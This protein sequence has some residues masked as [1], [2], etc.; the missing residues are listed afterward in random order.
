M[1]RY[2]W[3]TQQ[4]CA[5]AVLDGHGDNVELPLR[6]A[7]REI[8][9]HFGGNIRLPKR[10]FVAISHA[11]AALTGTVFCLLRKGFWADTG[12]QGLFISHQSGARVS[13]RRR[14]PLLPALQFFRSEG[15]EEF[16][17]NMNS[18]LQGAGLAIATRLSD[19][20]E[21]NY[22]LLPAGYH[23]FLASV[24]FLDEAGS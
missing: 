15:F 13:S 23:D 21:L 5:N 16:A 1:D 10:T 22:R 14:T 7:K 8:L 2:M 6:L 11:E 9:D 19:W 4:S 17:T 3:T 18:G 12:S 20:D 24:S